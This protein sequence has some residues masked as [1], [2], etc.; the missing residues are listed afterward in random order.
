MLKKFSPRFV[1]LLVMVITTGC[2]RLLSV[3]YGGAF[4]NFTPIGALALFGGAYFTQKWKAVMFPLLILF[5]SDLV[6]QRFIYGGAYGSVF[7]SGWYITYGVFV[8]IV[9]AGGLIIKKVSL[10]SV[11]FAGIVASLGHYLI[12]DFFCWMGSCV[13]VTTGLPY[14]R[15]LRGLFDCYVLALPF[16][17]SFFMGTVFYSALLF[18]SFELAL[19]RFPKLKVVNRS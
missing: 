18:G 15:D 19:L 12:T 7:Y 5:L 1:L 11:L 8:L 10:K 16:L 2:L 13:N 17:K 14:T 6:I 4:F 9:F 3:K